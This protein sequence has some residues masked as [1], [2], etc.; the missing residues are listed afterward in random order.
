MKLAEATLENIVAFRPIPTP[1]REQNLCQ[2]KGYD[3]PSINVLVRCYG[4]TPHIRHRGED[5]LA[6]RNPGQPARRWVI[7]RT[8]S[9]MNRFRRILIRW[10]K[11]LENYVAMLDFAFSIMIFDKLRNQ[12]RLLG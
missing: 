2:D 7:E 11:K 9:W 6:Y 3:Y 5:A 8:N 12:N 1:E 4:F 10:E